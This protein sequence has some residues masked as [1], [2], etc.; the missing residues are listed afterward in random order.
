MKVKFLQKLR[1]ELASPS[2]KNPTPPRNARGAGIRGCES[3]LMPRLWVIAYEAVCHTQ[4]GEAA[5]EACD[6][7]R[8]A[9]RNRS[10]DTDGVR[11]RCVLWRWYCIEVTH[12]GSALDISL[13][14]R[15]RSEWIQGQCFYLVQ[16]Y[17]NVSLLKHLI[18]IDHERAIKG[19]AC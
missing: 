17:P 3:S 13:A 11:P 8:E 9:L 7:R 15:N 4:Y 19:T 12:S 16:V 1:G 18:Y 2:G 14:F 10:S 6:E 5:G